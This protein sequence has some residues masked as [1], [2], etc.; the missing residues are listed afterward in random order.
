MNMVY[1]DD[2]AL[3]LVRMVCKQRLGTVELLILGQTGLSKDL[4]A[5]VEQALGSTWHLHCKWLSV[6][7]LAMEYDTDPHPFLLPTFPFLKFLDPAKF[8]Q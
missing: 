2:N 7:W 1:K 8:L 5:V 3:R 6:P 4:E